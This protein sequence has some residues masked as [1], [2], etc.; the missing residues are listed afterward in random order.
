MNLSRVNLSQTRYSQY[1]AL[2]D[3]LVIIMAMGSTQTSGSRKNM[4]DGHE[5]I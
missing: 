5:K 3:G 2:N 4:E 1:M